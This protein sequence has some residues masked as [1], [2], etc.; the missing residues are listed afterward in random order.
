MILTPS[1]PPPKPAA[2]LNN[3]LT[4]FVCGS[5]QEDET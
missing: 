5:E 4:R 2:H 3:S 1:L